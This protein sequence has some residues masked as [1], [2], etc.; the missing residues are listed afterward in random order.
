[1]N[2]TELGMLRIRQSS[3]R[4]NVDFYDDDEK[5]MFLH[6]SKGEAMESLVS[7]GNGIIRSSN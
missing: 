7:Y 4:V 1:M 3:I 5:R 2:G 6:Y